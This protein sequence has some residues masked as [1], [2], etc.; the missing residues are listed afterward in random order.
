VISE[1]TYD[2][3]YIETYEGKFIDPRGARPGTCAFGATGIR[4]TT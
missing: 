3:E 4:P 1:G 2:K